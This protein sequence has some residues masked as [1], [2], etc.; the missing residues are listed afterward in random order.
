MGGV[1]EGA[2]F[3]FSAGTQISRGSS[4]VQSFGETC[5]E[6]FDVAHLAVNSYR[7]R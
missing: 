1:W 2:N 4:L 5:D 6:D 7:D 3:Q